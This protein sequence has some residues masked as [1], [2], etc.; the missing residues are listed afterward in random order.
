MSTLTIDGPT[1]APIGVAVPLTITV[2]PATATYPFSYTI[3]AT[4]AQPL[5]SVVDSSTVIVTYNWPTGG[6]KTVDVTVTND[7]GTLQERYQITIGSGSAT[8]G[9]IYL[10]I[11][12]K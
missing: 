5:T 9:A 10:P 1:S 2:G 6:V 3:A 7:L 12:Q 8:G 4:D 11:V